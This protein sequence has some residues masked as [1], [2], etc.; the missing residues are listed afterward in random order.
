MWLTWGFHEIKILNLFVS[1]FFT[2][3]IFKISKHSV[4]QIFK[5]LTV[6]TLKNYQSR[7][8]LKNECKQLRYY[9]QNEIK[10][11]TCPNE[12]ILRLKQQAKFKTIHKNIS[13]NIFVFKL[14]TNIT[15]KNVL[16]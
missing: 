14:Q 5:I 6:W 8:K 7:V 10:N 4:V 15:F 2:E 1:Y 12:K 3:N 9:F 11:S 16:L 13:T